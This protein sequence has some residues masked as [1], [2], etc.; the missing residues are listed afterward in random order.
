MKIIKFVL[1]FVI[2]SC[3][4]LLTLHAQSVGIN[5]ATPAN[6]AV[7]D[8]VSTT[9]GI[10]IPRMNSIQRTAIPSPAN[11]LLV[12]DINTGSFWY[13]QAGDWL[14]LAGGAFTNDGGLVR[15]T[16]NHDIDDFVFGSE[17]LPPATT[18]S[19]TLMFF[20]KSKGAFRSGTLYDSNIWGPGL[21]G[22]YS[23][24]AGYNT[25]ASG[26][27]AV[28]FGHQTEATG[29][30][31]TAFGTSSKATGN[32]SMATGRFTQ[33]NAQA[34]T[35]LGQYNVGGGTTDAWV[36]TDPLFEIGNGSGTSSRANALTVLKNGDFI[37]GRE[38]V[39]PDTAI[40]DTLMFFDKS[41][42]AFRSGTLLN[43]TAWAPSS[44]GYYSFAS[45]Q[46]SRAPGSYSASIGFETLASGT[47]SCAIGKASTASG[48]ASFSS[49]NLSEASGNTSF[50]ANINSKAIGMASFATGVYTEAIG[51]YSFTTGYSTKSLSDH[52]FAAGRYTE[53]NG[54]ISFAVGSSSK[55]N[56]NV[57]FA[58]GYNTKADAQVSTALGQY[59][60]GGGTSDSWVATD[61]IF[62]IGIGSSTGSRKNAVTVLKN[63]DFIV[64]S[65][66]VPPASTISDTLMFFDKS[67]GAFRSGG[68]TN[69]T[70]WAP[71]SIGV[72]S[73]ASGY[74]TLASGNAS[75]AHGFITRA[76]AQSSVALGQSTQATAGRAIAVGTN[77]IAS[78]VS[79]IAAGQNTIALGTN[80]FASG[81]GTEANGYNSFAIG[82]ITIASGWNT[83][84]CGEESEA[85]GSSS[86]ASG[87]HSIANGSSS[88]A[89]GK[90]TKADAYASFT[91]G[92]YNVGGGATISWVPTDPVFEIGIGSDESNR[93][94][95]LTVLKNGNVGIGTTT[96]AAPIE[97]LSN[98]N[99]TT[100]QLKLTESVANDGAR[101]IFNNSVEA[102]NRWT[103]YGLADNTHNNS[104]FNIFYNGIG[105]MITANGLGYVGIKCDPD[106]DFHIRHSNSGGSG[107]LKL[108]NSA[109]DE[110]A[111]LY[112]SSG[113][114]N[115]RLYFDTTGLKGTFNDVNGVYS[116]VS[117]RRL[118]DN[119]QTLDFDW[120]SFNQLAP[121]TYTYRNDD[122]SKR[123][124]GMVAQDVLKIYPQLITYVA[125]EDRY[126]MDYSGFGVIAIK[127]IQEQQKT[128]EDLRD[129][130]KNLEARLV[131]L[132]NQNLENIDLQ[133]R[134]AALEEMIA[135]E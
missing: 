22:S 106:A 94:N 40:T 132:E 34:S 33:A 110:F 15:S 105:N 109:N 48:Y 127:A 96:P 69:S 73:L 134:L 99:A 31:S 107:G 27:Y 4:S 129:E 121:L 46:N 82:H 101:I 80:T 13:Y 111:R 65:D 23:F 116:T 131:A 28:A 49:G 39:P 9:K 98:G 61:P 122:A 86:F 24:S 56:G 75:L 128:I 37:V 100:P 50:A 45:G 30:N 92:R 117:D 118:K 10:L 71:D 17:S 6:T 7:L 77:T 35:A 21:L 74:N 84:A 2:V 29:L 88:F 76:T 70:A 87:S 133:I 20:D 66:D 8:V 72:Y 59:N 120:N 54:E 124:I 55:A 103:L 32:F 126:T 90:D 93:E 43:S 79:S 12:F 16:G 123:Y 5:T 108:Q 42:S 38:D 11:G 57:S 125:E 113:D 44:I 85:N 104:V 53:A 68:V 3:F 14:E 26:S 51:D 91:M 63:G 114:G 67:K 102:D 41:K 95:A 64:G 119:F 78:G 89:S 47:Y 1:S 130:N 135:R 97:I 58:S 18:I 36:S 25:K 52:A 62:E 115:L 112:V 81:S 60:V 19:D 83:F